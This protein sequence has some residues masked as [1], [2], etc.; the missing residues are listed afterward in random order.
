MIYAG[1]RI[2]ETTALTLVNLSFVRGDEEVR[3]A[4]GKATRRGSCQ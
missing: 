1:L 3:V 4:R 2:E